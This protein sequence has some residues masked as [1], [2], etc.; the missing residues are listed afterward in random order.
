[1]KRWK[2]KKNQL[3][4]AKLFSLQ[5]IALRWAIII[6][7]LI[8][9]VLLQRG[10]NIYIR[11]KEKKI[12]LVAGWECRRGHVYIP[13]KYA[14]NVNYLRCKVFCNVWGRENIQ[15]LHAPLCIRVWNENSFPAIIDVLDAPTP[16]LQAKIGKSKKKRWRIYLTSMPYQN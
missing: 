5:C 2:E 14:M 11:T 6:R 9:F 3:L 15:E 4:L 16:Q 12:F 13:W 1:M 8:I 7:F 10:L